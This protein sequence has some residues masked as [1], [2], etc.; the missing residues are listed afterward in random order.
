MHKANS[1]GEDE[2]G[3]VYEF[4]RKYLKA[5]QDHPIAAGHGMN[6]HLL[7]Y[8]GFSADRFWGIE[9]AHAAH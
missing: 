7:P 4:P 8:R 1:I 9:R 3:A 5:V 6:P 2:P